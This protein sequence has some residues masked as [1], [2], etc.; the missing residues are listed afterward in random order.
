MSRHLLE[1]SDGTVSIMNFLNGDLQEEIDRYAQSQNKTVLNVTEITE[2]Q[3]NSIDREFRDALKPDLTYDVDKAKDIVAAAL[4]RK[5][6]AEERRQA[7]VQAEAAAKATL[8]SA[9]TIEDL[10]QLTSNRGNPNASRI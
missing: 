7:H 2:E 3:V 1:M 5:Q 10:K 4:A 8:N 9:R 6:I